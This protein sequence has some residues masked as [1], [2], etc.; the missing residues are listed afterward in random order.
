MPAKDIAYICGGTDML[1]YL[2]TPERDGKHPGILLVHGAHGLDEFITRVADRLAAQGYAV[3]ALDLWGGRAHPNGPDDISRYLGGCVADRK[4]WT[5]RVEAGRDILLRQ[6]RTSGAQLGALGYCFGGST[7]LEYVRTGG[8][9]MGAVSFHGGLD[10]VLDDWGAAS[11]VRT[12]ICTGSDD[13][14]ANQPDLTRVTTAMSA[15]GRPWE[16]NIYGGVKHAFTEPDAPG[17][18]PF[19]EY[20]ENADGRSWAAMSHF[21]SALFA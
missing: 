7:V 16:V 4:A 11:A 20:D 21:F 8:K 15:A 17:R 9:I 12:L 5:A 1:G 14:M 13:P 6:P 3:L 10:L 19:A 2:A 18:P